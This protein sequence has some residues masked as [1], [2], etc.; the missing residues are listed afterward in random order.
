LLAH[1]DRLTRKAEEMLALEQELDWAEAGA[2][3][4]VPAST[5]GGRSSPVG[6]VFQRRGDRQNSLSC[7]VCCAAL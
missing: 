4:A 2:D 5:A 6:A 7:T 3:G 1:I